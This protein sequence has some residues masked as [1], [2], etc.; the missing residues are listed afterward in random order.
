[1]RGG[2]VRL[3]VG[4]VEEVFCPRQMPFFLSDTL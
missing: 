4:K 2:S 1:L 3:A